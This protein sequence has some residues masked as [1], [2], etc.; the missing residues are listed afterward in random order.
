MRPQELNLL[1]IFDV[2]MTEQSITRAAEQLSMTQPAVSNS[3]AKMRAIWKDE[4]FVKDGRN[5]QPTTYA[6][7]LWAQ[8]K[9][10]LLDINQAV[11]PDGFD[12]KTAKRTFRIAVSGL[13][14]DLLWLDMRLLFEQQAPGIN[15]HAVPYTIV[16]SQKMLE[17]AE[18]DLVIGANS[19]VQD[20][21]LSSHLYDT[22]YLCVM[23]HG[24]ALARSDFSAQA[25]ADA[26]HLLVSLSGDTNG[27]VDKALH[28][29]GKTRRVA[30]TVNH[31]A[32]AIPIIIESQLVATLPT[33]AIYRYGISDKLT[34]LRP[35][36][37]I[38]GN[39]ISMLWHK[40]QHNDGGLKWLR[41][42]L[43]EKFASRWDQA[44]ADSQ[45]LI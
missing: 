27:P 44:L 20:N 21:I 31:F 4:L 24:H 11:K 29:L 41:Q 37:N 2:I 9:D 30:L 42:Q 13:V 35:P 8:V 5:I 14:V 7:N 16:D 39:A 43:K 1:V 15:L 32:S 25:Y 36:L 38:Q 34:L 33:S 10:P 6:K 3:V 17:G 12:H 45:A 23:R 26:D 40:R 19:S 18:V 22:E 28:Q